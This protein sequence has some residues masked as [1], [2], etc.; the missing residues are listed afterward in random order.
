MNRETRTIITP[1]GKHKVVLKS[2]ITG[3]EKRALLKPF[4]D[5][6]EVSVGEQGKS[7]FKTKEASSVI[8]KAA[9][10]VIETI[11]VS[12]DGKT[13]GILDLVLDMRNKDYGFVM[14]ELDKISKEEDFTQPEP[15]Q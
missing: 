13:E 14:S 5:N 9:N 3:R 7:E 2:W 4:T 11:I 1:V 6:I 8:E 12:I 15:K 10:L